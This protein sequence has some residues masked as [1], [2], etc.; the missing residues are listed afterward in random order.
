MYVYE[1]IKHFLIEISIILLF[2]FARRTLKSELL[3]P[4]CLFEFKEDR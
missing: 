3:S 4:L 2:P 1:V